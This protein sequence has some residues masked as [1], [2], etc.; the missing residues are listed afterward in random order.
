MDFRDVISPM[1]VKTVP[2]VSPAR[3]IAF[4]A[5]RFVTATERAEDQR[6]VGGRVQTW[7]PDTGKFIG[8]LA[9]YP[10][11]VYSL[12]SAADD[13]TLAVAVSSPME[14]CRIDLLKA[15]YTGSRFPQ[16]VSGTG[17]VCGAIS[18]DAR[19]TAMGTLNGSVLVI[20]AANQRV[21]S[22][23][24]LKGEVLALAFAPNSKALAIATGSPPGGIRSGAIT[25]ID[26]ATASRLW[27]QEGHGNAINTVAFTPDGTQVVTGGANS[28]VQFR[29]AETGAPGL[30]IEAHATR[31]TAI[32]FS[33][34]GKSM[35]AAYDPL[36]ESAEFAHIALYRTGSSMP[37][38]TLPGHSQRITGLAF[39]SDARLLGSVGLDM[40]FKIWRLNRYPGPGTKG[41]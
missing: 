41:Q 32:C 36:T 7:N 27:E 38:A 18:P 11:S 6:L 26:A 31:V 16:I 1:P 37:Y 4:A 40:N 29:N 13:E 33:R 14:E 20:S 35:A 30:K 8:M 3:A 12:Q 15:R 17:Q 2:L 10:G 5:N 23:L 9:E 24:R 28:V 25:M 22:K 19:L 39:S 34:D 21:V